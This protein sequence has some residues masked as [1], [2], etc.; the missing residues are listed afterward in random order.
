MMIYNDPHAGAIYGRITGAFASDTTDPVILRTMKKIRSLYDNGKD[1]METENELDSA[2]E[3][4]TSRLDVKEEED[5]DIQNIKGA[6]ESQHA[7]F[8][9]YM[10]YCTFLLLKEK[11]PD[12][13]FEDIFACACEY[14][15]NKGFSDEF[16]T[17]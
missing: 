9:Y 16:D 5:K 11:Y 12:I 8:A 10:F 7:D 1:I 14:F 3:S 4:I 15:E 17:N 6:Y 13:Q 2:W